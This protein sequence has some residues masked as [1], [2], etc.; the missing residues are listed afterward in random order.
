MSPRQPTCAAASA[1]AVIRGPLQGKHPALSDQFHQEFTCYVGISVMMEQLG[2][3]FDFASA[4]A[5][6]ATAPT[7][8]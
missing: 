1:S 3:Q 4:V 5:A 2:V 7:A 6:S 8:A